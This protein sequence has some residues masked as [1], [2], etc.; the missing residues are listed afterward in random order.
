MEADI[1]KG[2]VP[3]YP[4]LSYWEKVHH[5]SNLLR[6]PWLLVPKD[7]QTNLGKKPDID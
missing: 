2:M 6:I 5:L 1:V 7:A 4:Y 3:L